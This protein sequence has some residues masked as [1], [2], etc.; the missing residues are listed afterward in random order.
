MDIS[1]KFQNLFRLLDKTWHPEID[2]VIITGGRYSLKS[3]TV[4]I[5]SLIALVQHKWNVLYTRY[6]NM[7]ITD[8]IKP[9]VSDKVEELGLKDAVNDT[10]NQIECNKNRISFKGIKTG[11]TSRPQ[12]LKSLSGFNLFVND[13]AEEL[14]NFKVFKK[15]FYS[16]RSTEKRNLNYINPQSNN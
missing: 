13:E 3:Y 2:T 7:S 6:T 14:P 15:I 12:I 10:S 16:I 9:E 4:S 5:F 11:A 1:N 8:S